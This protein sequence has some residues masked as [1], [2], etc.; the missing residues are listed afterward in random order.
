MQRKRT[1]RPHTLRKNTEEGKLDKVAGS[2]REAI[3]LSMVKSS[4]RD[5][6]TAGEVGALPKTH[7]NDNKVAPQGVKQEAK[8]GTSETVSKTSAIILVLAIGFHAFF[9]GIAFGLQTSIESAG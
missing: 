3:Q 5:P 2:E 4:T 1:T 7:V 6:M 9:E 8:E